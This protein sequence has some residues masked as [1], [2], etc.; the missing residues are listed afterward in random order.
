MV[1]GTKNGDEMT[2]TATANEQSRASNATGNEL[3]QDSMTVTTK[4]EMR[5]R[6]S[7]SQFMQLADKLLSGVVKNGMDSSTPGGIGKSSNAAVFSP[8]AH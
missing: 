7:S 6:N 3:R 8:E 1:P 5:L 2:A 4:S